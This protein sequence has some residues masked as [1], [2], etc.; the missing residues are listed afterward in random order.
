MT[1]TYNGPDEVVE[2][3][4]RSFVF[5]ALI[6][7]YNLL[8]LDSRCSL[9]QGALTI[10]FQATVWVYPFE[11]LPLRLHQRG[12]SVSTACNWIFNYMIV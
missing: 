9:F 1:M 7:I 11:I 8:I 3:K 2:K 5:Y 4:R 12:S 6:S 10:G